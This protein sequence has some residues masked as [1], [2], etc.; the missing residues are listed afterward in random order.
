M[1]SGPH[2]PARRQV[3]LQ[4]PGVV[5][6]APSALLLLDPLL[7]LLEVLRRVGVSLRAE[8]GNWFHNLTYNSTYVRYY[9]KL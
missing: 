3:G 5:D 6:P 9:Q 8:Y 7:H 4:L 2:L 1:T